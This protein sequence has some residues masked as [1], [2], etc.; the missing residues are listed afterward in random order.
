[1]WETRRTFR[2]SFE[3]ELP[4]GATSLFSF[5]RNMPPVDT[6]KKINPRLSTARHRTI[7]LFV[8]NPSIYFRSRALRKLAFRIPR[9]VFLFVSLLIDR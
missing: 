7:Y 2:R 3:N 6:D 8:I 9:R 1:M 5:R 4:A